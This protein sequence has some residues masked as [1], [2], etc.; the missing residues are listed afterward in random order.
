MSFQ[1]IGEKQR[2]L[3]RCAWAAQFLFLNYFYS[4]IFCWVRVQCVEFLS[5]ECTCAWVC[6]CARRFV[7]WTQR[8]LQ[9]DNNEPMQLNKPNYWDTMEIVLYCLLFF[10]SIHPSIVSH[11]P[12]SVYNLW[13]TS[14]R[15]FEHTCEWNFRLRFYNCTIVTQREMKKRDK[16][17]FEPSGSSSDF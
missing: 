12:T 8:I 6:A 11:R 1:A 3:M 10:L 14:V 2:V 7:Y 5:W 9:I 17:W 13:T 16:V 4:M 15:N